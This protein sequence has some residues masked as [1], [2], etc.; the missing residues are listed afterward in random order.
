MMNVHWVSGVVEVS[1]Y[2]TQQFVVLGK[3]SCLNPDSSATLKRVN[4]ANY[5]AVNKK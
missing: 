5:A 2:L 1:T 4:L 3:L